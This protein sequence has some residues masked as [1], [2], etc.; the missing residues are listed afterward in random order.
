MFGPFSNNTEDKTKF[1]SWEPKIT[2]Y[3]KALEDGLP[4]DYKLSDDLLP[5]DLD[6]GVNVTQIPLKALS[7][8]ELD[9]TESSACVLTKRLANGELTAVEVFKAFAKRA[10]IAHQ[11]TNCAMEIFIDEGLKRAQELDD[12]FAKT[13]KTVG[14]LHGLPVSLKEHYNYKGKVTHGGYVCYLDNVTEEWCTTVEL[15]KDAGA[16][17]FIRTTEPQSLMHLCSLNN[18]TGSCRNPHNTSLTPGGSSSGEGAIAAMKGSVFGLGSDIGGSIR[19]PAAFC[20]VWGL[21]PTQQRLSMKNV[22]C[23]AEDSVQES[24]SCVL[25]PLARSGEDI[26]LFMKAIIDGEPW[27]RDACALPIPWRDVSRPDAKSLKVAICYDDG[28]VKPSPPILRALRN[29][30]EKLAAAGVTVV[31]W[32][33]INVKKIVEACASM[34]NADGNFAQKRALAESGEPLLPLTKVALSFGCG[35]DGVSVAKNQ[36]LNGIRDSGRQDYFSELNKQ[37]IDYIL[38]PTYAS[39]A[40]K[41]STVKYW[42]YTSLWN[43]LDYPN[44][45]FPTGLKVDPKLDVVDSEYKPRND[46][47]AYEY[48]LYTDPK[49]FK[50]APIGLQLTGRRYFDEELVKASQVIAKIIQDE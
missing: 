20:G 18:I 33:P 39:V 4:A 22:L 19:C 10:T 12:Y 1:K 24:V 28:L 2:A 13:G 30:A 41:P 45:V 8:S 11:L 5:K 31:D 21:R 43:I 26:D 17:F 23:A 36:E 25:G 46:Y 44:V 27:K 35:D 9:I 50:D 47:E 48:S 38:C 34:Y 29:A 42:G 15:L 14:I 6:S 32:K 40:A 3:R 7:E 37:G 16:V 49:D